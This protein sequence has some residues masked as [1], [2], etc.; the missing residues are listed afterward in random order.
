MKDKEQQIIFE[1]DTNDADY[2]QWVKDSNKKAE[3]LINAIE[4]TATE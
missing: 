3:E 1:L 4:G 2:E